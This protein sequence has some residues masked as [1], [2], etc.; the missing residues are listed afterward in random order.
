MMAKFIDLCA[1]TRTAHA[2]QFGEGWSTISTLFHPNNQW[3]ILTIDGKQSAA[4]A[5]GLRMPLP[6]QR[7]G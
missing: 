4:A 1:H 3:A 5:A 2:Q 7:P 6:G